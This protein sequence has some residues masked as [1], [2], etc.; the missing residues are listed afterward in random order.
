MA[1]P[2]ATCLSSVEPR[3]PENLI[4][5]SAPSLTSDEIFATAANISFTFFEAHPLLWPRF[6]PSHL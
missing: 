3:V 2:E 4:P 5:L 6:F 1:E